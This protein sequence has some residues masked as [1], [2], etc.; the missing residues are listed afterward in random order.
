MHILILAGGKSSRFKTTGS[1]VLHPICGRPAIHY[2]LQST[3]ALCPQGTVIVVSPSHRDEFKTA[4]AK[5]R[6]TI[7]V[8]PEPRGSGDAV[9]AGL[10]FLPETGRTLICYGDMPLLSTATMKLLH[11]TTL[12]S[13]G[14]GVLLAAIYPEP[15]PYGR[16][17]MDHSSH[18]LRVVEERDCS[19]EEL[20]IR[21]LNSGVYCVDTAWLH[22]AIPRLNNDN[23]Q[24][25]YYLTD[26]V[27][28]AAHD[29]RPFTVVE[30]NHTMELTGMNTR[31]E[32]AA[33]AEVKRRDINARHMTAGIDIIDPVCAYID[34]TVVI[35]AET[36]IQPGGHLRGN[37]VI[38][39]RCDI[40]VGSVLTDCTI[41]DDMAIAPY[42][43]LENQRGTSRNRSP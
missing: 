24:G 35:G 25:E 2:L 26:I 22:T 38:G 3:D 32:A 30:S 15:K 1:K 8:Q 43:V 5:E 6:R 18:A 42:T 36:R 21:Q 10:P 17:I 23:A 29:D 20:L 14:A 40:G 39:A 13:P 16:V 4:C 11:Q 37:T 12:Q 33:I 7:A 31:A 41:S 27:G 28:L 19:P 9:R 34:D